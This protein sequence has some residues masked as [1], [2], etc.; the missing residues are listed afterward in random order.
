MKILL[1]TSSVNLRGG[2][3]SSYAIDFINVYK[4]EYE[5]IVVSNDILDESTSH[6]IKKYHR[7]NSSD[8]SY[9][10]LKKLLHII[11]ECKPDIILNSNYALLSLVI[12]F[13]DTKIIKISISHLVDG[14]LALVAGFN[15]LYYDAIISLSDAGA[16]KLSKYYRS[17]ERNKIAVVY[18]FYNQ[19]TLNNPVHNSVINIVYPGG[20]NLNKNP[21][22]VMKILQSLSKSNLKYVFYWLGNTVLPGSKIFGKHYIANFF[23]KDDRI[24]FT[25]NVAREESVKIIQGADVF[26]L[27][28]KKEGCPITL[29]EAMSVGTIPVVS[30]AKHASSEIIQNGVNGYVLSNTNPNEYVELIKEIISNPDKFS[31]IKSNCEKTFQESFSSEAW[32]SKMDRIFIKRNSQKKLEINRFSYLLFVINLTTRLQFARL[33]TLSNSAYFFFVFQF[34]RIMGISSILK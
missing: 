32:K 34:Y 27:P 29:L 12:P 2:G 21:I 14:K 9:Q 30:D 7:I 25:G 15:H 5:F 13:I 20:G 31:Q 6:N 8:Y 11:N 19:N 28:S 17:I 33:L 3:I 18:N 4:H 23:E 24:V 26:L 1:A 16:T 10:N 22:L